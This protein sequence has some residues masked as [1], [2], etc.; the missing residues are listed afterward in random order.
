MDKRLRQSQGRV[1][2]GEL[3]WDREYEKESF[4]EKIK[5]GANLLL[6]AQRRMGK[7][8]LMAEVHDI[9]KQDDFISVFVDLQGAKSGAD[10]VASLSMQTRDYQNVWRKATELLGDVVSNFEEIKFGDLSAKIRGRLNAGNW[11]SKGEQLLEILSDSGKRV[12]LFLDE[13]PIMINRMLKGSDFKIT[14]ERREQADE[15]MSWL[16]A[17]SIAYQG[18][19]R[20][21]LSGSIGLEPVLKQAGLSATINNFVPFELRPWDVETAV[22]CIEALGREYGIEFE[23]GV[24]GEMYRKL[25]CGIP[26]H[27]QMFFGHIYDRCKKRKVM[28][29]TL[30]DIA[31]VYDR[32]MLGVRG[33][34]ELT[35]YEERLKLVLGG[36]QL[37]LAL[38]M[39]T[40][41]A[42]EGYLSVEAIKAFEGEYEFEG[43]SVVGIQ[44]EILW[45]L[46]HDGYLEQDKKGYVF[47]SKLL[48]DWWKNRYGSFY[49]G[50]L[51]RGA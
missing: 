19:I 7:T 39:L 14:A 17:K 33:H 51:K 29:C 45:V 9:L 5:E 21:V 41:A 13:V 11:G 15:F 6:V 16:R 3:F 37:P 26:H 42:V 25:G 30:E 32:D 50:I 46:E 34:A 31:D 23:D 36:E 2:K 38:E 1:V 24:P 8:S 18:S 35:H 22:G 44:K 28:K 20:F 12:V 27:V 40:E 43:E 48:R 47:V 4:V 49:V 10:F